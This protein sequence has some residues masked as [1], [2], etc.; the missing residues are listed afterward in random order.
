MPHRKQRSAWASITEVRRGE[1]Y[2]IRYWASGADGYKRRSK[3]IRNATRLDAERVRS[4]L[5]L[6]HSEDAPCPTVAQTWE[7][8]VLPDMEQRV[9]TGDLAPKSLEQYN[10]AWRKHVEPVWGSVSCDAVRPLRV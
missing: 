2:R 3:T 6:E 9:A 7:R 5:M 1:V 8:W 4:E 10:S